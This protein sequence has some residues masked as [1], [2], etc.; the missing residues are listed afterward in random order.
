[1]LYNDNIFILLSYIFQWFLPL[2]F[3]LQ[4]DK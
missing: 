4:G 1:M 3:D 2:Y